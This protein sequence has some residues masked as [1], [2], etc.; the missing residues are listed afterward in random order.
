M[1]NI[2][3]KRLK[4]ENFDREENYQ[5]YLKITEA[6]DLIA[7]FIANDLILDLILAVRN[8][9]ETNNNS[10]M[11]DNLLEKIKIFSSPMALILT[12][13]DICNKIDDIIKEDFFCKD[14]SCMERKKN[15]QESS[16]NALKDNNELS[17]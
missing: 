7:N 5:E 1:I 2:P 6:A 11:R 4:R 16:D 10:A 15:K 3:L 14:Y 9:K 17:N 12:A 13:Y 8:V